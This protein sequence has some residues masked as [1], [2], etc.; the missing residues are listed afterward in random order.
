MRC[1]LSYLNSSVV[2]VYTRVSRTDAPRVEHLDAM[3]GLVFVLEAREESDAPIL[4]A[5]R[6]DSGM[7]SRHPTPACYTASCEGLCSTRIARTY[8]GEKAS[9]S[10]IVA[11]S[12]KATHK[13]KLHI[14]M[15]STI[16][17]YLFW[18]LACIGARQ[19]LAC[20][21]STTTIPPHTSN[22]LTS[23]SIH[24]HHLPPP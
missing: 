9:P 17:D 11:A 5:R 10:S 6:L 16:A 1:C 14:P 22:P 18:R 21:P 7:G 23:P 3:S 15:S 24:L 2:S 12:S 13:P 8:K 19:A 4:S 20:T